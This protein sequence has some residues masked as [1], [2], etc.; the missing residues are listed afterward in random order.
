MNGVYLSSV[1]TSRQTEIKFIM[2]T[3]A[4]KRAIIAQASNRAAI[5]RPIAVPAKPKLSDFKLPAPRF[6]ATIEKESKPKA[7]KKPSKREVSAPKVSV[8]ALGFASHPKF[9]QGI[10]V[11]KDGN[12]LTIS[13]ED[14]IRVILAS[15]VEVR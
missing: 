3:M 12:K 6:A 4:H 8:N 15:F 10:I 9:G 7:A 11:S 5:L 1:M 14:G 2:A 13:F